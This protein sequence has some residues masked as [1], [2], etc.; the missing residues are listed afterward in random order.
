[1]ENSEQ[2]LDWGVFEDTESKMLRVMFKF[3]RRNFQQFKENYMRKS[4]ITYTF[5]NSFVLMK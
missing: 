5:P 4:F 3:E 2:S 1:M